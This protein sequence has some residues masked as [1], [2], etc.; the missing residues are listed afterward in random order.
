MSLPLQLTK[1]LES[2]ANRYI[3]IAAIRFSLPSQSTQTVRF[4]HA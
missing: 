3:A 4:V 2:I 1:E